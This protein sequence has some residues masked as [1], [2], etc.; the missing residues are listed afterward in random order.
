MCNFFPEMKLPADKMGKMCEKH[1]WIR[2]VLDL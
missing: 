2:H 1:Y